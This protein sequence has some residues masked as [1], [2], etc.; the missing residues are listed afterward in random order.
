MSEQNLLF[1]DIDTQYD[2]IMPDGKLYVKN[3][4]QIIPNL[5]RL[6][7][8]AAEHKIMI[9]A[10]ADSHPKD[11]P[12]FETFPPHCLSDSSGN[13]KIDVTRI[14]NAAVQSYKGPRI[15]V[16]FNK[17]GGVIFTKR[18]FD[19]F[20]NPFVDNFVYLLDPDRIVVYG[21][22]TDFCVQAAAL[23]LME[24]E[25]NVTLVRDAIKAV[26]GRNEKNVIKQLQD[27]GIILKTTFEILAGDYS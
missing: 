8:Y 22:A 25:Y 18:S 27:K 19:V 20:G 2:F 5:H 3:A 26:D 11:D 21:V 16:D 15:K 4:E 17:I 14:E 13:R 1:F 7:R 23:S 6:T 24:R 12:E 9:F 10:S